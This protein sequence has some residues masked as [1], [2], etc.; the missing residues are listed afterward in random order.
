M[1]IVADSINLIRTAKAP[2]ADFGHRT[3]P[4]IFRRK[5]Q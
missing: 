5:N 2:K 4:S 1:W 3:E